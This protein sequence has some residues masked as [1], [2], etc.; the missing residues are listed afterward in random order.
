MRR[1]YLN[2]LRGLSVNWFGKTGVILSTST[3][4]TFS[5]LEILSLAG[6]YTNAYMGLI[7][8]LLFPSLFVLGLILIPIGWYKYLKKTGKKLVNF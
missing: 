3:F 5:F 6:I 2:I 7:T 1:I 8:Y 4:L